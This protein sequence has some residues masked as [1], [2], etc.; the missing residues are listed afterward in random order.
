[1]KREREIKAMKRLLMIGLIALAMVGLFA[2]N[3]TLLLAK[4]TPA[5]LPATASETMLTANQL[6]EAGQ[7]AQAGQAYQQLADQGIADSALF[8][9]LGNAY[10]KQGDYGRAVLNYRRA[11]RLAPRDADIQV[12]LALAR[13]QTV[14]QFEVTDNG[15]LLTQVGDA[16]G[17][18]FTLNE[19][20]MAALGAWSLLVLLLILF[21]TARK[22]SG[23]RKGLQYA[24]VATTLVLAVSILALGSFLYVNDSRTEG[25]IV[26]AE[27]DVTSGPGS[28]YVTEFTLHSGAEVRLVEKRTN[29]VR[30]AVPG[31]ELEGWLP[32]SAVEAVGG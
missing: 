18:M 3:Q 21:S 25:V 22:G 30:L 7:F 8:Y 11:Q 14:D 20:A 13:S 9:N 5:G 17:G 1:M 23:W 31:G 15:G 16:V 19:L 10:F 26:A 24:L 28:Q 4:S 6:Y 32:A 12:N 27:A 29:W 2:A